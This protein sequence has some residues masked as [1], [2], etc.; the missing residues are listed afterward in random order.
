MFRVHV[1]QSGGDCSYRDCLCNYPTWTNYSNQMI[2]E[3][4]NKLNRTYSIIFNPILL[5]LLYTDMAKG[6]EYIQSDLK[7]G[8]N[9]S[10]VGL[11]HSPPM[12]IQMPTSWYRCSSRGF[13]LIS[14][15]CE[16]SYLFSARDIVI[17]LDYP[18]NSSTRNSFHRLKWQ[19]PQEIHRSGISAVRDIRLQGRAATNQTQTVEL[20]F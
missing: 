13:T 7:C 4:I 8:E 5:S 16:E 15:R 2:D 18:M 1:V 3:A 20:E 17:H 14:I 9:N 6:T 19:S 12:I 10:P 11:L